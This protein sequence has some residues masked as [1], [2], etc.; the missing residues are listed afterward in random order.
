MVEATGG[1]YPYG[2]GGLPATGTAEAAA[3]AAE[4]DRAH[5]AVPDDRATVIAPA[6]APLDPATTT[7]FDFTAASAGNVSLSCL[8][9]VLARLRRL[10]TQ[11]RASDAADWR[12]AADRPASADADPTGSASGDPKLDNF[13]DLTDRIDAA[14]NDLTVAGKALTDALAALAALRA[15][16]ELRSRH[17][18]RYWLATRA[19]RRAGGA[20][21]VGRV[22]NARSCSSRRA[23]G[24]AVADR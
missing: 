5:D 15:A 22:R 14:A 8:Q 19:R 24:V 3:V 4:V 13:K 11:G 16:F 7:L 2:I 18:R 12:R 20:L 6:S 23:H 1:A 21:R 9:P 17:G 10:I